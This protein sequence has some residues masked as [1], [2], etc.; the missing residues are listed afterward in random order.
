[1]SIA[2]SPSAATKTISAPA[3]PAGE[4]RPLNTFDLT[5][6]TRLAFGVVLRQIR[7]RGVEEQLAE[8]E[9]VTRAPRV[10]WR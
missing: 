7:N 2:R 5:K 1:L 10:R 6:R 4:Q 8:Q 9:T 3:L